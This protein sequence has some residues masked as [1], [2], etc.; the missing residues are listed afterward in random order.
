M[1][2]T[3]YK[4]HFSGE[5]SVLPTPWGVLFLVCSAVVGDV[6]EVYLPSLLAC[7]IAV[8]GLL[9]C[10]TI[11]SFTFLPSWQVITTTGNEPLLALCTSSGLSVWL[12]LS[13]MTIKA[14]A[15][16]PSAASILVLRFSLTF[17]RRMCLNPTSLSDSSIHRSV[18]SGDG[19]SVNGVQAYEK[20]HCM[21]LPHFSSLYWW[22]FSI[23]FKPGVKSKYI[24][25][26]KIRIAILERNRNTMYAVDG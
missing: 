17:S 4:Q 3:Q 13:L 9:P 21:G 19:D 20:W 14:T 11:H 15:L 1:T 22:S 18:T 10:S 8:M 25:N 6:A 12:S 24:L 5:S 16:D 23:N 26:S 2:C 7:S